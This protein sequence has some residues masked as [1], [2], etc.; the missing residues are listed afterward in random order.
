MIEKSSSGQTRLRLPPRFIFEINISVKYFPAPP[1]SPRSVCQRRKVEPTIASRG[2][3]LRNT[4]QFKFLNFNMPQSTQR[5]RPVC[6]GF[7]FAS[8]NLRGQKHFAHV[9]GFTLERMFPGSSCVSLRMCNCLCNSASA[10]NHHRI[11]CKAVTFSINNKNTRQSPHT[12]PSH[13]ETH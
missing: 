6:Q 9:K 3:S 1:A 12:L 13:S 2:G 8:L 10:H 5:C 4:W 11:K 7:I